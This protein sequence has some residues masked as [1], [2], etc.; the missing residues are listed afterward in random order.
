MALFSIPLSR[1]LFV[2]LVR[3]T[4]RIAS[5]LERAYPIPVEYE[6][7]PPLEPEDITVITDENLWEQEQEEERKK[8]QGLPETELD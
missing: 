8:Q 7:R 5:A 6:K 3:A 2:R 4:E 1:K